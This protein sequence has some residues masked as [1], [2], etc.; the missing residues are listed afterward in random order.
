MIKMNQI[1]LKFTGTMKTTKI[2]ISITLVALAT[3]TL[4]QQGFAKKRIF[5]GIDRQYKNLSYESA[6]MAPY[7][8]LNFHN[9]GTDYIRIE[10]AGIEEW[11]TVPFESSRPENA[12]MVEDWMT[13]PFETEVVEKE[14]CLEDWMTAPFE[15]EVV[16]KELCLE[17]WMIT[18]FE[19]EVVEEELCMEDWMTT[20]FEVE[21]EE[22]W[23]FAA[24]RK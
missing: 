19:T 14:L 12:L 3:A 4:G 6:Y 13:T 16:E 7:A 1:M 24:I 18:P 20:P 22:E 21:G 9:A 17:D 15:T 5:S 2:I 8:S 23:M 10:E 11:M